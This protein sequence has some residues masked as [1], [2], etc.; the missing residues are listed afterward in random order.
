MIRLFGAWKEQD[1]LRG[2]GMMGMMMSLT[3]RSNEKYRLYAEAKS[4]IPKNLPPK[5]YEEEVRR[6]AKKYRI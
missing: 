4:R 1:T 5:E 2:L 3:K 6:L